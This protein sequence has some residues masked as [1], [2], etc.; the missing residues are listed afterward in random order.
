MGLDTS[1]DC[2]HGAYSSFHEWRKLLAQAI[3]IADLDE[4][5]GFGGTKSWSPYT[6][7]PLFV[8]LS[9]SDCDGFIAWQDCKPLADRLAHVAVYVTDLDWIRRTKA[10]IAGLRKAFKLQE[11]VEFH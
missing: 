6:K 10:F 1:H 8:L 11:N 7:D 5:E 3:G 9:H 2:W 4:M